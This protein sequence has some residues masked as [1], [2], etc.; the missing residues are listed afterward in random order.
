LSTRKEA[1]EIASHVTVESV[2]GMMKRREEA[3]A[4]TEAAAAA[5]T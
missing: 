5:T 2:A 1:T 4:T 3:W